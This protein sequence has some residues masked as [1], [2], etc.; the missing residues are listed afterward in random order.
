M[1][2]ETFKPA[3]AGFNFCLGIFRDENEGVRQP[4]RFC[5]R[6]RGEIVTVAAQRDIENVSASE[7]LNIHHEKLLS[8]TI[9]VH[10]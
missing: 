2:S 7:S 10:D 5:K 6:Q 1:P 8:R 9:K 4:S 3:F